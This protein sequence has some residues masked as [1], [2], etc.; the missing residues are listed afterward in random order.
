MLRFD[1]LARKETAV[2][3]YT[4]KA[5]LGCDTPE[6]I[7]LIALSD[8]P[9]FGYETRDGRVVLK[10]RTM[11]DA[12]NLLLRRYQELSEIDCKPY[13]QQSA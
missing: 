5:C 2:I 12:T 7:R 11:A 3:V 10:A 6:T 1:P 9:G 4:A 13:W 8:E